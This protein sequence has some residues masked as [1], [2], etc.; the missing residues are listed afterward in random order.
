MVGLSKTDR[1]PMIHSETKVWVKFTQF[2]S[3]S[4]VRK[5]VHFYESNW[6]TVE[7]S[8]HTPTHTL[9]TYTLPTPYT[10][11][12]PPHT[13]YTHTLHTQ[14]TPYTPYTPHT[15][16]SAPSFSRPYIRHCLA[17]VCSP[18]SRKATKYSLMHHSPAHQLI[19]FQEE[20]ASPSCPS[21][22]NK[23]S[24]KIAYNRPKIDQYRP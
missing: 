6:L 16:Q 19:L 4:F 13:P 2:L 3:H 5:W 14:H 24:S 17:I 21:K 11:H 8:L 12:T 22:I 10:H 15:R 20:D 9:H 23:T 7:Y 18:L 1:P